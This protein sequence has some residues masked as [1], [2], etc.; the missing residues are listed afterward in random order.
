MNNR[1][2]FPQL[3]LALGCDGT[4]VEVGTYKAEYAEHLLQQWPGS[5]ICVDAWR[6]QPEQD[7]ILNHDQ[8]T[9]NA[10]YAEALRRLQPY[11]TR[12]VVRR[13]WSVDAAKDFAAD[14][15]QFDAVYLDAAHDFGNVTVDLAVWWPLV[16]PGGV[17]AGHDYLNGTRAQG[18]PAEFGVKSAVD[19]FFG[20]RNLTVNVTTEDAFPSW[21]VVKP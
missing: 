11:E 5:L 13:Q 12:C 9:M 4:L 17:F 15:A 1:R 3:L 18:Y 8:E 2:E 21:W 16:R 14:N 20:R 19:Q 7:D 6:H 10:V